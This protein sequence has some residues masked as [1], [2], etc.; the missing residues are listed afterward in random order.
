MAPKS[1]FLAMSQCLLESSEEEDNA[2]V[3]MAS[4]GGDIK[5][6]TMDGI[7]NHN[8]EH[9]MHAPNND[10][11]EEDFENEFMVLHFFQDSCEDECITWI[12]RQGARL[13]GNQWWQRDT[14][15]IETEVLAGNPFLACRLGHDVDGYSFGGLILEAR[16]AEL[17]ENGC[18]DDD[19][20]V[21]DDT[22]SLEAE[23]ASECAEAGA[24]KQSGD[25]DV[26]ADDD[27]LADEVS[28]DDID[29]G[30]FSDDAAQD[31]EPL[32]EDYGELDEAAQGG[33]DDKEEEAASSEDEDLERKEG[34]ASERRAAEELVESSDDDHSEVSEVE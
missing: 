28:V 24:A 23:S 11:K 2:V 9:S 16:D 33:K 21:G 7:R 29:L 1:V 19:S 20:S 26:D 31:T 8:R 25:A 34:D 10:L 17:K 27:L 14:E 4:A 13:L 22:G 30:V 5:T 3:D 15:D 12:R 6:S 18:G 32:G